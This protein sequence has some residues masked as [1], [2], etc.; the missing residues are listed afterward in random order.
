VALRTPVYRLSGREKYGYDGSTPVKIK[1]ISRGPVC[2]LFTLFVAMTGAALARNPVPL[3]TQPLV[4]DAAA[5]GGPQLT[6]N[7]NGTGFVSGSIV[8]WNGTPRTTT[9]LSSSRLSAAIAAT[10]IAKATTASVTVVDAAP[11]GG[12]SNVAFFEVTPPS[13]SVAL[14]STDYPVCDAGTSDYSVAVGDFNGDGKLDLV[15]ADYDTGVVCVLL[16]NG[17]GTFRPQV[18]Y[19][20]GTFPRGVAVGDFNGDGKLDLVVANSGGNN[21]SV[22][23]GNGDGTFQLAVNYSTGSSPWSVAVA[24]FNGDGKLDLVV[25]NSG[26]N[27]VSVLLGNGDG[28]F[29]AAVNYPTSAQPSS[30]GVGDFNRDG[31][32]DLVTA[33]GSSD[34]VSVLLGNGDGT[35]RPHVDYSTGADAASV[36]VA[37]FND[38][39]K[40]DLAVA[41]TC[42]VSCATG[43]SIL[44]G[45]GD[46]TFQA[47]VDYPAGSDA[48]STAV[49]DFNGDGKLDLAVA[50]YGSL[51]VS[52]LLGNGDGTFQPHVDYST[53]GQPAWV[54]VGDFNR[55]GRVDLAVV[56]EANVVAVL[57]QAPT[58][59]LAKSSLTFAGQV[60][61]T[62]SSSQTVTLTNTSVLSLT[63]SGVS[64]T[65]TNATDFS[66]TNT[67][68]SSLAPGGKCTITVTFTPTALGPRAA[69]VSITDNAADSP[70]TIVLGGTGVVAGSNVTLSPTS[71]TFA[72][73]DV[74]TPSTVQSVTLSNYGTVAL[75]ISSIGITG[76]DPNDF[77]QTHTC[78]ASVA[79]GA[80]CTINVTFKPTGVGSRTA[81]LS[82]KDTAPGSPQTVSLSGT[83][84]IV[85]L[86]ST[87]LLFRC[88][89]GR[90]CPPPPQTVTL[91][92]VGS[93]ILG[94][95]S[96]TITGPAFGGTNNCGSSVGPGKSCTITV[97][98]GM[99]SGSFEGLVTI[100]DNGGASPQQVRLIGFTGPP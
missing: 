7:V 12:T 40:L 57:L 77:V 41:T 53:V 66:Q 15:V 14:A 31:K 38:D 9:F 17:D 26:S 87:L 90:N 71:L 60:V 70:E 85:K 2:L 22:L 100:S 30:V 72:T 5:P 99:I 47:H 98:C 55:D 32:L 27:N 61:G 58:V 36:T 78:A 20:V 28:T 8:H 16:G 82:V 3:I 43:V 13:S 42:Y 93:T 50:N 74:G 95:S 76:V 86:S 83:G 92:N 24:D 94:I 69:S 91:T 21:V 11:G 18:Q 80:S 81:L 6:L 89:T 52:V 62:R 63:I 97:K 4:P 59:S 56:T 84:T 75:G 54:A 48:F 25:A 64:V 65:G 34:N 39:G 35:F 10:D 44:L 33:N 23:L 73:Q 68:A 88:S 67:C 49:G 37:D 79:P 51:S 19:A 45:N 46:G 1:L 29:Q 96:I